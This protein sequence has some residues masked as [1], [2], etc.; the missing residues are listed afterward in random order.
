MSGFQQALVHVFG[1]EGGLSDHRADRGGRT[2]MGI[3]AETWARWRDRLGKPQTP[4]D[5]CT[6][7]DAEQIYLLGYWSPAKCDGLPWPVSLCHFDAA[8][9]HGPRNAGILLQRALGVTEDGVVGPATLKAAAAAHP[10]RL[11]PAMVRG[12]LAFYRKLAIAD[13]SQRAFLAGWIGR[14][15][16]LWIRCKRDVPDAA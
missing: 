8:V 2:Q 13:P 9:Q 4:V 1:A 11:I 12:R 7:E 5:S 14:V 10:G 15:L 16:N 3:T 6:R